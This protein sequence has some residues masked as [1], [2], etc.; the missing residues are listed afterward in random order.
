MKPVAAIL[1]KP[2]TDGTAEYGEHPETL[3]E[4]GTHSPHDRST[5]NLE[6]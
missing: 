2:S 4:G 6:V 3:T 5:S 1:R